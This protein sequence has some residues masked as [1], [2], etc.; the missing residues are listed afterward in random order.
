MVILPEWI[1]EI[2]HEFV[3]QFQGFYQHRTQV[4]S[5]TTS[6]IE[7]LK[8]NPASWAVETVMFYLHNLIRVGSVKNAG[9]V[10]ATFGHFASASLS[11]LE[12]LLG[13]YHSCLSAL[14][15]FD[16][17]DRSEIFYEVFSARLNVFYHAGISYFALRRYGDCVSVFQVM[18]SDINRGMKTGVLKHLAGYDQFGKLHEKMLALIAI[19]TNIFPS[20]KVSEQATTRVTKLKLT[21]ST[22]PIRTFF[23]RRRFP[24][25]S[26]R[27]L[28]TSTPTSW[29]KS[30]PARTATKIYSPL[31]ALNS[32]PRCCPTMQTP[33]QT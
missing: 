9:Q 24:T 25:P 15:P 28:A 22:Y 32:S 30:T 23:A 6:D 19:V 18:C 12:C 11:R 8:A 1:F 27:S 29:P 7:T 2:M 33:P 5:R 3:Y 17:F 4:K 13:D 10:Q 20:I 14:A 16:L 21:N 31:R 26:P